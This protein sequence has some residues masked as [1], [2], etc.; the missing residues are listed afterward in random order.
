MQ[1]LLAHAST[2]LENVLAAKNRPSKKSLG[3]VEA[4]A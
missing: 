1:V 2:V 3:A 4:T